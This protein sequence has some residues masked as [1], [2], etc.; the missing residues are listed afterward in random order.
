[1][2]GKSSFMRAL[3]SNITLALAGAP[4]CATALNCPPL[5][6]ASSIQVTD[7]PSRGWSRFYAEVRRICAVI[8]RAESA[9]VERPVLFLIDEMLS[10]TNSRER[11][12]ASRTIAARLIQAHQAAGV[13]TTHDLDLAALTDRFPDQLHLRHFSDHFDGER[14]IFDYTLKLG[15]ARTTNALLVLSLEGIEV[16]DEQ[17][18]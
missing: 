12:L 17:E 6:I 14:L 16:R 18:V 15:V 7:D 2:S 4:V 11:R 3:A 10:G 9:Q 8:E 5:L 1:M 13:I